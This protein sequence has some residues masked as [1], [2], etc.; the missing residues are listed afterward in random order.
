[1]VLE[2]AGA[3]GCDWSC[4]VGSDGGRR[5][6]KHLDSDASHHTGSV[7]CRVADKRQTRTRALNVPWMP[8]E[9]ERDR[10]MLE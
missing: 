6:F 10:G 5:D 3:F 2:A 1:M 7:V 8:V 4:N 9:A